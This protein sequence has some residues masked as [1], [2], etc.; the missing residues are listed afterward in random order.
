LFNI[1]ANMK[2]MTVRQVFYQATV[3]GIG[4]RRA[5]PGNGTAL[6]R[7]V[8]SPR[9]RL[10]PVWAEPVWARPDPPCSR[11]K[12]SRAWVPNQDRSDKIVTR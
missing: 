2:P 5:R 9:Q 1:V 4:W 12:T 3:Q 10:K 6:S 11:I 7:R 8:T